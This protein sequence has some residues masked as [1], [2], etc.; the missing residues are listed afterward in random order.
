LFLHENS[1]TYRGSRAK[2]VFG[3]TRPAVTQMFSMVFPKSG[4]GFIAH[5]M[6]ELM[7]WYRSASQYGIEVMFQDVIPGPPTDSYQSE[8]YY[9]VTHEALALFARQR[10]RILH[11]T[12]EEALRE[13]E[14]EPNKQCPDAVVNL[15]L[16]NID[17][18]KEEFDKY[19]DMGPRHLQYH[20]EPGFA[21]R[22]AKKVFPIQDSLRDD[23]R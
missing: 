6:K 20:P 16:E 14:D 23:I 10:L 2:T 19:V 18:T 7:R 9:N 13:L 17:M 22:L 3:F 5:T 15:F 11:M 1:L 8:G 21:L 4:K 12:R